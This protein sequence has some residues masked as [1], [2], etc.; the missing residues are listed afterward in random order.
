MILSVDEKLKTLKNVKDFEIKINNLNEYLNKSREY[1]NNYE[2]KLESKKELIE[3]E[4]RKT[5]IEYLEEDLNEYLNRKS[6]C[7]NDYENKL[8]NKKVL[9]KLEASKKYLEYLEEE[10]RKLLDEKSCNNQQHYCPSLGLLNLK[11]TLDYMDRQYYVITKENGFMDEAP[12]VFR[13]KLDM[14]EFCNKKIVDIFAIIYGKHSNDIN[15]LNLLDFGKEYVDDIY[16][17]LWERCCAFMNHKFDSKEQVVDY[18]EKQKE[19]NKI[20]PT[21]L[22]YGKLL[23]YNIVKNIEI[24]N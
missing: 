14:E 20:E 24:D 23:K 9:I 6:G 3:I 15:M 1:N 11:K 18:I 5:Y 22:I 4:V 8:E 17:L 2:G 12:Y 7:T 16:Y 13:D 21:V 19:K 10:K